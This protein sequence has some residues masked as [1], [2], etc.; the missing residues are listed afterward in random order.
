M[1]YRHIPRELSGRHRTTTL[2]L[3]SP[4]S[5]IVSIFYDVLNCPELSRVGS[6]IDVCL[7]VCVVQ[8]PR[9]SPSR[10][11]DAGKQNL[12]GSRVVYMLGISR[13]FRTQ[14]LKVNTREKQTESKKVVAGLR[15]RGIER[16]GG[17]GQGT[18]S[19]LVVLGLGVYSL[20]CSPAIPLLPSVH[21]RYSSLGSHGPAIQA[22]RAE[23][24]E[25][26]RLLERELELHST[27]CCTKT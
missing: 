1:E 19:F 12:R 15:S 25:E 27:A 3:P 26:S 2:I 5:A 16:R 11:C 17:P 6:P 21:R 24:L 8:G 13:S 10:Q 7:R 4:E 18:S 23:A 20:C 22:S 14:E 9:V